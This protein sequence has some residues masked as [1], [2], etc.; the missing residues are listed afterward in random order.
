M[1]DHSPALAPIP[2]SVV[3]TEHGEWSLARTDAGLRLMIAPAQ[4]ARDAALAPFEGERHDRNGAAVLVAPLTPQN[5]AA[6]RQALPWLHPQVLGLATSAGFGD[7]L[8]LATPG[9]VRALRATGGAVRPIFAQQSIRENTRTG[10]SPRIV[11]DDAMWGAFEAGWSEGYGADAD[12]LKTPADVESCASAG[13]TF[14]TI[15]PGEH[16]DGRADTA[17]PAVLQAAA[18]TLPWAELETDMPSMLTRFAGLAVDLDGTRITLDEGQVRRAAVKYGRAIAHIVRMFR[19][20]EAATRGRA[21]E[22]EVS[23]D[24][25]DTP[26]SHGEHIVI[27]TELRRLGV[28]WVSLAPRFIGRFEKGVDYIGDLGAFD[29]DVGVHAAIAR[30]FGPYKISL[31]SGSDKFSIYGAAARATRGLVHLKTA[32]TSYLEALR[33]VAAVSPAFF[34]T[35]Y[36]FARGR[37]DEDK[38]SYHVSA[39]VARTPEPGDVDDAGL[40]ALLEDFDVREILHV[41]FGSVLTTRGPGGSLTYADTL[42]SLLRANPDAYAGCL[43]RHFIRHLAPFAEAARG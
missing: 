8:G 17:T 20:V 30:Q 41:T 31:H 23:V 34:R 25:T 4:A 37:Y 39:D 12:H 42:M 40:A 7:R 19:C 1:Q 6:L 5:A 43:E 33:A 26:T 38:A 3:R 29:Q 16:V 9:H 32:G 15:D 18:N 2:A 14:F 27:A 10:R 24:E 22:L 13:F 11:I 21:F 35:I 36:T 28:R